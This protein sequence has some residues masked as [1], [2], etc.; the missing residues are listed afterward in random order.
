M[1]RHDTSASG[2]WWHAP[3]PTPS[4]CRV[5]QPSVGVFIVLELPAAV[6]RFATEFDGLPEIIEGTPSGRMLIAPGLLVCA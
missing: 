2:I 5:R 1:D 6:E 4:S 3:R